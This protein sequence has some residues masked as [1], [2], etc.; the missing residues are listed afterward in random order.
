[1]AYVSAIMSTLAI[2]HDVL[3][4][5]SRSWWWPWLA[6]LAGMVLTGVFAYL[7]GKPILRLRGNYLAMATLGVGIVMYTLFREGEDITGGSDG[8][9]GI[10]RLSIGGHFQLWPM[11]RY[12]FLVW[13]VAIVVIIVALNIVNSRVGRALRAIHGSE[14]AANVTGVDTARYKLQILVV[15]AM[16]ASLPEGV[17]RVYAYDD[18]GLFIPE[19]YDDVTNPDDA[20]PV[21]V[22]PGEDTPDINF[23]L[24][25]AG[26]PLVHIEPAVSSPLPGDVFTVTIAIDNVQDLGNF[27]L[28]MTYYPGVVHVEDVVL[29][30]FLGSTGREVT[31]LGPEIDNEAGLMRFGAFSIGEE[32]G[33]TG[34][35]AL[36]I[37]TLS[38]QAYGES[39][40]HLQNVQLT[41]I[42]AEDIPAR[43]RD[44]LVSV[45]DCIFG[46]FDC[47]CDVDIVD[48]MQVA[49]RW[50]S[51]EGD[52]DYD[53][54][55][56]LD[57]DGD[58]DIVDVA[59][60]AA[61][62]GNT[63]DEETPAQALKVKGKA[64][65]AGGEG[66]AATLATGLRI[67]PTSTQAAVGETLTLQ[68]MIDE[69]V[70]LGGFEFRLDYDPAVLRA[71]DATLGPFLGSTGRTT[72]PL[73]PE[74]D[75]DAGILTFGGLSFGDQPGPDGS[76]LLAEITFT[77]VGGGQSAVEF[78]DA[79]T[80]D[81]D[82]TPQG[83]PATRGGYVEVGEGVAVYLPLILKAAS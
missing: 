5:V 7:V 82:G 8:I 2:R 6:M 69:A 23:R 72:S 70:D 47:D 59:L 26:H 81:S 54:L 61:A 68:V 44:G 62:W 77:V 58:I 52:P 50:G 74:M 27:E 9:A 4:E 14:V 41:N 20:T 35:G 75:N 32:P 17:Y 48:V 83:A 34:S 15:S 73:G 76:G 60:V 55:Y 80:T 21:P 1:G 79:Q 3:P 43:L 24:A 51:E 11:E 30:D 19:Y 67:E 29:G 71:D 65:A 18:R 33:P 10:P 36:A 28:E 39:P 12:Y 57:H 42:E 56:D 40:L 49:S 38:A 16:I 22:E 66:S 45:G 46:D 37:V 53:P 25:L 64:R 63:C 13:A 78:L 31:P